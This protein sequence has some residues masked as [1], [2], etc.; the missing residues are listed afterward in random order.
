VSVEL[1]LEL[2]GDLPLIEP[3]DSLW[4]R[5]GATDTRAVDLVLARYG[6]APTSWIHFRFRAGEID[7]Q[8]DE[9]ASLVATVLAATDGDAL[10]HADFEDVWLLRRG[11]QLV[12]SDEDARWPAR[13]RSGFG[14]LTRAALDARPF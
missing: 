14:D 5:A 10:L 12:L 1:D 3:S 7:A 9:M 6:F 2:A 11:G 4:W 13:R 8:L